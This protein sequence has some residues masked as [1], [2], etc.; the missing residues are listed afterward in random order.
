M[1]DLARCRTGISRGA[2]SSKVGIQW[3]GGIALG[4][5]K[6]PRDDSARQRLN[7]RLCML[8]AKAS[9]GLGAQLCLG[10]YLWPLVT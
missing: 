10:S 9:W 4:L 6:D 8:K 2:L 3:V 7:K 1:S 5:Y